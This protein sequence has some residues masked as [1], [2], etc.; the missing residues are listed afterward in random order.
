MGVEDARVSKDRERMP[1]TV[2]G[3][4]LL[5][6]GKTGR[7]LLVRHGIEKP[8]SESWG[9][10]A[11]G[12][13]QGE[14]AWEAV[15]RE[16]WEEAQIAQE[17]I[18]IVRGRDCREPH[19]A[20]LRGNDK[21]RVGIVFSATYS[22]PAVNLDGWDITGDEDVDRARFFT[23]RA[24]LNLMEMDDKIY[25]P[26]FNFPQLLRWTLDNTWRS[27]HRRFVTSR[28][29]QDREHLIPGLSKG[30][31]LDSF[32]LPNWIYIPPYNE[33]L[34]QSG[35]HGNPRKTNFARKRFFMS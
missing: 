3:A 15:M 16:A 25:R 28:W 26:E 22:G 34:Q 9:L 8:E 18:I 31:D 20:L 17:N 23:W 33:W 6:Q 2:S 10:I 27:F 12:I 14:N 35:I 32:G 11:G 7:L 13:Q 4:L 19:V 1:S 30:S 24:V 21:T 29:L 5:T